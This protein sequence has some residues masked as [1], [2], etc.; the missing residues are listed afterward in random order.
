MTP[1]SSV[2]VLCTVL[3]LALGIGTGCS[4][5]DPP[6]FDDVDVAGRDTNPDGVPYPAD[7]WGLEDR[8]KRVPGQ[9]LPN[10]TFWGYPDSDRFAGLQP[11]SFA[12]YYDPD[13]RR[14]KLMFLVGVVAYCPHCQN[15]TRALVEATSAM[16][17]VGVRVV[18]VMFQGS[19]PGRALSLLD[20]DNWVKGMGTKFTVLIDA[21]ARRVGTVAGF[22]A[23]PWNV[24]LD[25][26]SM[27]V[28]LVDYGELTDVRAFVDI[29]VRWVD[30]HGPRP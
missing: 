22:I 16:H 20:V 5:E 10:F 4:E 7:D 2:P 29:A 19:K 1:R 30:S 9:R 25:T 6:P 28:L 13:Q 8:S 15:E 26:R 18:Q 17:D 27:E 12:D 21:E 23:V 24:L 3:G 11:V 14:H